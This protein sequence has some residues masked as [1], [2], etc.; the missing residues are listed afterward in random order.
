M[1]YLTPSGGWY[2]QRKYSS[3]L[4]LITFKIKF[5]LNENIGGGTGTGTLLPVFTVQIKKTKKTKKQK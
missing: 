2:L 5:V 1:Y 4:Q 3:H